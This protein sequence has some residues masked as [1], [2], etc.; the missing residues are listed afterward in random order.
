MS[1]YRCTSLLIFLD[2]L[3]VV[4][5]L[6]LFLEPQHELLRQSP[7]YLLL[8]LK[9]MIEVAADRMI[10]LAVNTSPANEAVVFVTATS[11]KMIKGSVHTCNCKDAWSKGNWAIVHSPNLAWGVH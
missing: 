11:S 5:H 7:L 4:L 8:A 10:F 6:Q 1:L 9:S 3:N 2:D